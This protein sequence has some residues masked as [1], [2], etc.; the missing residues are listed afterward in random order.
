[1]FVCYDKFCV[2]ESFP[3]NIYWAMSSRNLHRVSSSNCTFRKTS[4]L[5]QSYKAHDRN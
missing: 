3:I 4:T 5:L 1:M 2:L